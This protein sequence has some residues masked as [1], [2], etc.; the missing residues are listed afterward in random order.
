MSSVTLLSLSAAPQYATRQVV[1]SLLT[2]A[3]RHWWSAGDAAAAAGGVGLSAGDGRARPD[4]RVTAVWEPLVAS[5]RSHA[6]SHGGPLRSIDPSPH[7]AQPLMQAM[8]KTFETT[9][10]AP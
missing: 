7:A 8:L 10:T 6:A 1:P 3:H 9:V 5:H 4:H 2:G